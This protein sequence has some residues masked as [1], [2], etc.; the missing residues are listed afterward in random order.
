MAASISP[1]GTPRSL[2]RPC[3]RTAAVAGSLRQVPREGFR[4]RRSE[5]PDDQSCARHAD[6]RAHALGLRS[7][8]RVAQVASD[9]RGDFVLVDVQVDH[10]VLRMAESAIVEVFISRKECRATLPEK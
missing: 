8:C 6:Y 1:D 2:T 9:E 5:P 7:T 3:D 4:I 10:T